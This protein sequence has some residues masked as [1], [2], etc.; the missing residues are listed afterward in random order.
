M[1]IEGSFLAEYKAEIEMLLKLTYLLSM[2]LKFV[3]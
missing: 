2:K 1:F 3:I